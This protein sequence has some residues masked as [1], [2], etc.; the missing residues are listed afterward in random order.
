MGLSF[1][2]K[3]T[4]DQSACCWLSSE[5]IQL[6]DAEADRRTTTRSRLLGAIVREWLQEHRSRPAACPAA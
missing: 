3:K 1:P 6:L 2:R 4:G 5:E